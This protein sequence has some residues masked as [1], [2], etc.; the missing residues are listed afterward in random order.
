ML[1]EDLERRLEMEACFP[2]GGS[3]ARQRRRF[4]VVPDGTITIQAALEMRRQLAR[5]VCRPPGVRRLEVL[6]DRLV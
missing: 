3:R 6:A 4:V 1:P 5:D 2:T